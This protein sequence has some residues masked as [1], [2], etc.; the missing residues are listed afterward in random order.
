MM[1]QRIQGILIGLTIGVLLATGTVFAKSSEETLQVL[2]DNIKIMIDGRECI[3]KDANGNVVEAFI[4][5]GT[6]YLPVRAIAEALGKEVSWDE[7]KNTVRI[8]TKSEDITE[9]EIR[10]SFEEK[11]L[12][13][14]SLQDYKINRVEMIDTNTWNIVFDVLPKQEDAAK[15]YAGN[16]EEGQDGWIV[17]KALFVNV[18]QNDGLINL[19]VIGTGL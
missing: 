13:D 9:D 4:S 3:P 14:G 11:V 5:D 6:T 1:K 18:F 17:N 7:E 10:H 19:E 12:N 16:G 2:Y 8:F 15:W